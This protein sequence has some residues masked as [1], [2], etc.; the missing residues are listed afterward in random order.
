MRAP[1]GR[2]AIIGAGRPSNGLLQL[3]ILR[4]PAATTVQLAL[5]DGTY[6]QLVKGDVYPGD[7]LLIGESGGVSGKKKP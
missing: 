2:S 6:A 5:D 7:E 1:N 3:W 4:G